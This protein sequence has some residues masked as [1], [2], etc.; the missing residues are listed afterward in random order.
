MTT[1][2]TTDHLANVPYPAG[3]VRVHEWENSDQPPAAAVNRV[4]AGSSSRP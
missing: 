1:T 2:T 3:A 4:H